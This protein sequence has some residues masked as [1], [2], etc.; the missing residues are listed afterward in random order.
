MAGFL[1]M[2]GPDNSE[3]SVFS[4]RIQTCQMYRLGSSRAGRIMRPSGCMDNFAYPAEANERAG[5]C[6]HREMAW[7]EYSIRRSKS[8]ARKV[9]I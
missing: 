1:K 3:N 4:D 2:A 6:K 9:I 5:L 8:N 7:D